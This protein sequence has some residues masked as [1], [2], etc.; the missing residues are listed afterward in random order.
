M[1]A[2]CP[3]VGLP[4]ELAAHEMEVCAAAEATLPTDYEVRGSFIPDEALNSSHIQLNGGARAQ[5]EAALGHLTQRAAVQSVGSPNAAGNLVETM[6]MANSFIEILRNMSALSGMGVMQMPGLVGNVDI[7]RQAT[8]A[9]ATWVSAENRDASPGSM[10]FDLVQLRPHDLASTLG[11]TRRMMQQGTPAIEGL[12]RLDLAANIS[13][14]RDLA[15]LHG[16]N[17]NGQPRG[18]DK[19]VGVNVVNFNQNAPTYNELVNMETQILEGNAGQLGALGWIMTAGGQE[20]MKTTPKQGAGVEGNF[21][22]SDESRTVLG[23]P[24]RVSQQV[25]ADRYFLAAWNQLIEGSWGGYDLLVDPYEGCAGWTDTLDCVQH[26]RLRSAST[27][28]ILPRRK[29]LME[30]A[31]G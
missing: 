13:L 14:A 25:Q 15:G 21:I 19:Q 18:V 11:A 10:T 26:L 1:L 2:P 16:T 20:N 27:G 9:A 6:L 8:S 31:R 30:M 17:V 24:V 22:M 7:P 5:L 23:Y 12:I 3:T 28:S 29:H 4:R